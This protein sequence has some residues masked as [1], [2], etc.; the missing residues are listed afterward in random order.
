MPQETRVIAIT[1]SSHI[2]EAR[3]SSLELAEKLGFSEIERGKIALI[4]TEMASNVVKHAR[5]GGELLIQP[6]QAG[7]SNGL[8]LLCLDRGPGIADLP[9]ALDDGY[10]TAGTPGTGLGAIRRQSATFDVHSAPGMGTSVLAQLWA[11]P[12]PRP[13]PATP[14]AY[15]AVQA[16]YPGQ[17]VCGDSW[18]V[19]QRPGQMQILVADGLGHGL[20]AAK[21][22]RKALLIF[23]DESW[24]TPEY[25]VAAL[26]AGMRA[27]RGAAIAVAQVDL[28]GR[29]VRFA[30]IGN[31]AGSIV[32]PARNRHL[33]SHNGTAGHSANKI[34]EFVYPWPSQALLVMHS[35]G[36]NN[37]WRVDAYPGLL[38]CH[39]SLIAGVL[40][41]DFKRGRDDVAVVVA[42]QQGG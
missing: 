18:S 34:Q 20:E 28:A 30:G 31:I 6:I 10:S 9:G 36:L 2:A 27:T 32:S 7:S 35:D 29:E 41:R 22:A 26:H 19:R 17:E 3:R 12:A 33:V 23:R 1:D 42:R 11:G 13:D 40:Y 8:E 16:P 24:R 14:L 5:R 39:P 25:L 15:G 38:G 21:A 4:A 37:R